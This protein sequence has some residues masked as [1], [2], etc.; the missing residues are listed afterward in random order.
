MIGFATMAF[1][2]AIKHKLLAVHLPFPDLFGLL[3]RHFCK[4]PS[5]ADLQAT[6]C[7]GVGIGLGGSSLPYVFL[8]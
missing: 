3:R 7:V 5:Y 6:H 8:P 1:A 2:Q 4:G